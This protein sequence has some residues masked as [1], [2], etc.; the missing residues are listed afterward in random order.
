VFYSFEGGGVYR[1]LMFWKGSLS[2]FIFSPAR[3]T[4]CCDEGNQLLCRS[5]VV[6]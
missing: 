6:C 5:V 1:E 4:D 3:D 2:A